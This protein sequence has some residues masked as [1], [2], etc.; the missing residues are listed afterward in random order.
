MGKIRSHRSLVFAVLYVC[1][2]GGASYAFAQTGGVPAPTRTIHVSNATLLGAL[3]AAQPGDHIVLGNATYGGFD[4]TQSGDAQ[5][6]IVIRA[7]TKLSPTITGRITIKGSDVWVMGLYVVGQ[8]KISGARN[9][10]SS[11]LF[12]TRAASIH[13]D[14]P[15]RSTIVDHND[16]D[17]QATPSSVGWYG[18]RV[19]VAAPALGHRIYRNYFHDAARVSH[20]QG[21]DDNSAIQLGFGG[22]RTVRGGVLVEYNLFSNWKGDAETLSAKTSGHTIQYNT[23]LNS[24]FFFNRN[25]L[26]NNYM[27][28]WFEPETNQIVGG[29][30]IALYD[31][32][33]AAIG[34][35]GMVLVCEG[36]FP[37]DDPS[38]PP[39][40]GSKR[41]AATNVIAAGNLGHIHVGECFFPRDTVPPRGTRIEKH[42]GSVY[43]GPT[44]VDTIISVTSGRT[45][46]NTVKLA[47]GDVGPFAPTAPA[48]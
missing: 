13:L 29:T 22:G 32:D 31:L 26:G 4:V 28:N 42:E 10:V 7:A 33:N 21:G 25:G 37:G 8:M 14:K 9:R 38:P 17:S 12:R 18:V 34:N 15:A 40:S 5:N 23:I 48:L 43:V 47:P 1:A 2:F 3:G 24:K 44:A 20:A 46:P 16:F 6:P 19:D 30:G 27:A 35:R 41:A 11:N 36:T 45:I 39:A